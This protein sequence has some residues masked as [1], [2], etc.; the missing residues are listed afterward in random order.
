MGDAKVVPTKPSTLPEVGFGRRKVAAVAATK[1]LARKKKAT[2]LAPKPPLTYQYHVGKGNNSRLIL[3]A[4]RKR[5]WFVP[6]KRLQQAARLC[7]G[8]VSQSEAV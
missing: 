1:L 4:L 2:L 5:P 6:K 7:L 8:D 3:Q